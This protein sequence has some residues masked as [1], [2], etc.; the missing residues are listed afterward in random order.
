MLVS[1]VF[2]PSSTSPNTSM[3]IIERKQWHSNVNGH[4]GTRLKSEL[5]PKEELCQ[6][7]PLRGTPF[8]YWVFNYEQLPVM[9]RAPCFR[10]IVH[11]LF[12]L[13]G[14]FV[15][16]GPP[17]LTSATLRHVMLF[18]PLTLLRNLS[19]KLGFSA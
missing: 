3:L 16:H 9:F 8:N 10:A 12:L 1:I 7:C 14:A 6:T 13:C 19:R 18:T 4:N 5:C 11:L 15:I 2:L 17:S